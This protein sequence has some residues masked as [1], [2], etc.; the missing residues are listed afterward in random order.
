[1]LALDLKDALRG[2]RRDRLYSLVT[3]LTLALTIGATTAVFAIV[4]GVLLRPLA[5][6]E[7]HRL[8]AVSEVVREL[9]SQYPMLPVN[10]RHFDRW[11]E[12]A[13]S[14]ESL[15]EYRDAPA[16]LTGLGDAAQILAVRTSGTLFDVLQHQPALG[17][18]LTRA[19]EAEDQ[20]RVAVVSH[21]LWRDRLNA[22]PAA[23][24]RPIVL[25]G[26]QHVIV[27]ILAE[28]AKIPRL[29]QLTATGELSASVDVFVPLRLNLRN[30]APIG[31]F[32]YTVVGRLRPGTDL[33]AAQAELDVLQADLAREAAIETHQPVGLR[34]LIR[35]L[36]ESIVA[37]ARRG[38]LL[39][40]AAIAAVLLVACSNLANLALTRTLVRLRD[41]AIRTALGATRSRL[42][43]RVVFEQL[44]LAGAGGALGIGVAFAALTLFVTT[45]PIDL[46]RVSD[47]AIDARVLAAAA[48]ASTI[49]GLAVAFVPAWRIAGRDVQ[50]TLRAGGG[51]TGDRGGLRVRSALLT[52]QVALSVALL[53]VTA[54]LTM[55]FAKLLRSDRGFSSESVVAIDVSLPANR[56]G[57]ATKLT[58][59]YDRLLEQ[60]QAIPGVSSASWASILPLT[61][62]N[63]VDVISFEGDPRPFAEMPI[64]NY[65]F[66]GP[67]YFRTMSIVITRGRSF[68][69]DER[70]DSAAVLPAVITARTAATVWPG[71]DPIGRRFRRGDPEQKPFEVVG[72]IPDGHHTRIDSV[73]PLMVYVPYWFR[74]RT[75]ASLVIKTPVEIV[76]ISSAVRRVLANFDRDI[77]IARVR[78]LQQLVDEA[79]A[80]RRYQVIV[81]IVFGAVGLLIAMIGVYAVTAYGVS[82]R[83]REMNIRVALG[84]SVREVLGLVVRQTAAPL[85]T[86]IALGIVVALAMGRVVA[87][88][89]F[90][91]NAHDPSVIAAVAALVGVVGIASAV[92]AARQGLVI[93]PA[94]ALREE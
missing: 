35:P 29:G 20:P 86:G 82:R 13:A 25:D 37:S 10:P 39:L 71:L 88:L 15:A 49:A 26:V 58:A 16:N 27:G 91:M 44:I 52:M 3:I 43:A 23:I 12:K 32:N 54:L 24:G 30:F 73:S 31:E 22:D 67:D 18:L 42:I 21:A 84:A 76:G 74:S 40:L 1:M 89:L 68:T 59:A 93:D 53:A 63:W 38:L 69:A 47:V 50:D 85:T 72:V 7:S 55:S 75:A 70:G 41:A 28:G 5:Y 33:S 48:L 77:A 65:R 14:F 57:D 36:G 64:A 2:L 8:V 83:R 78:P 94:A 17:R 79:L 87:S 80:S 60:V 90:E 6:R 45:P 19:D 62:E 34:S 61:G 92:T 51:T 66:V 56:Y 81:F 4:D 9:A 11:R 46:P